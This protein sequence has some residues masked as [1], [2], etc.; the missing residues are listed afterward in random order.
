MEA[1]R[2]IRG[3][4]D[5]RD[6]PIHRLLGTGAS[7]SG[8]LATR[9]ARMAAGAANEARNLRAASRFRSARQGNRLPLR[10][11]GRR[12]LL[13]RIRAL[14]LLA[15]GNRG[16]A[17]R[18]DAGIARALSATRRARRRQ[19]RFVASARHTALSPST[20]SRRVGRDATLRSMAASISP[21]AAKAT[22]NCS[23]ITRTRRR[24][25]TNPPSCNGFGWSK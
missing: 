5:L 7:P 11:D 18:A 21:M 24:A 23:N 1:G 16:Q 2:E 13:G 15:K 10:I 20:R 6:L 22:P 19:R 25:F 4:L 14:R 9:A 12:P 8:A 3:A 17:R